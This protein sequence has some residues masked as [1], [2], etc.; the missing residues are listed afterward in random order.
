[1]GRKIVFEG[2]SK[3]GN[4]IVICYPT[5]DD[6]QIFC[7]YIN[8]L[9]EEKTF[10][11]FQGEK[12][13]LGQEKKYL[14][15][16]LKRI[17]NKATVELLVFCNDKLVGI[18]SIDMKDKTESH[19]GVFGI[20][21]AKEYRGEGIGRKFMQFVLNEAEKNIPQLRIITLG[22]FGD[23]DLAKSMYEKFGFREYGRLPNGIFYKG[24]YVDHIYMYKNI[25]S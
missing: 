5:K 4:K 10:V 7:D 22:V 8:N 18:S 20:S 2:L 9:S 25:R 17:V 12:V 11:R 21:I 24:K 15:A 6:A 14:N 16:Q 1:M 23:N 3:K 13:S 19:E